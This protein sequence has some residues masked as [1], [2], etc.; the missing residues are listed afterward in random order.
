MAGKAITSS[1]GVTVVRVAAESRYVPVCAL[2]ENAT[3]PC[4]R[5]ADAAVEKGAGM[6]AC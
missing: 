3:L 5:I 4:A 2:T 6:T 1:R